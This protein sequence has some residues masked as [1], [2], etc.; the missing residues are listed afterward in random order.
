MRFTVL[1]A[2]G[3]IG[4]AVSAYLRERG[5]EVRACGRSDLDSLRGDLGHMLY[6]IGLTADFRTRPFDTVEAHVGLL[7]RLLAGATFDSFLYL[8]STRVYGGLA[9]EPV[10]ENAVLACQPNLDGLYNL[11]KLTGEALC[12]CCGN[13]AVR[14]ARLANVYGRGQAVETFLGSLLTESAQC[15]EVLIREAPTSS[16]DYIALADVCYLLEH[17]AV[18]GRERLYNV[19]SGTPVTHAALVDALAPLVK[20][21]FKF[22]SG[23]A[24]RAFPRLDTGRIVREFAFQPRNVLHDLHTLLP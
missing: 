5:H 7:S 11:S 20:G 12:L 1:G 13:P 24:H 2:Q 23:A 18:Q 4:G 17:I 10:D 9:A 19:A 16:K 6:A 21:H 3:F 15:R 22:A 14:V 8:S